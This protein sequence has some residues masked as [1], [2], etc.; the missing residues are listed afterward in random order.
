MKRKEALQ[1]I[2]LG[3]AAVVGLPLLAH[4]FNQLDVATKNAIHHSV[5]QWCFSYL[6]LEEL[7]VA[8]KGMGITSIDLLREDQWA[9]AAKHGLT[10]AMGYAST[11]PL[12]VGFNDPATHAQFLRD[13][14]ATIPKAAEAGIKNLICFSGNANGKT[15]E[16]GLENCA[17]GLEPILAIA[18]KYNITVSMELLNSKVDHA[19]YQCDY[20]TWGVQLCEK[21]GSANFKLLYDIYHMQIMEGNVIATIQKYSKYISHY[22]TAG[23]PGRHEIDETQE[24]NYPAIMKAIV[25]TGFT[26][27]VAQEFMPAHSDKLG[28]LKK[29]ID[30]CNV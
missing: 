3:S 18:G 9:V 25:A 14:Q 29:A 13:F 23:V 4:S 11:L 10:C 19:D 16:E 5:C 8:A 2:A 6:P 27:F 17:R 1:K 15:S 30:L 20:T 21:L 12:N 22:H 24:L 26:G 7:V 28:S